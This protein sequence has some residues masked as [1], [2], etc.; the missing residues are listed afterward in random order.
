MCPAW[1]KPFP[2]EPVTS[3]P[4]LANYLDGQMDRWLQAE[5]RSSSN[6]PSSAAEEWRVL[7]NVQHTLA[8]FHGRGL[9]RSLPT[10]PAFRR[11]R[12]NAG[13]CAEKLRQ[14][15]QE[16]L[17]GHG[18][19]PSAGDGQSETRDSKC[20]VVLRSKAAG[21]LVLGLEVSPVTSARYDVLK[22]LVDAG[23]DGLSLAELIRRS[24]HG[25]ARNVLKNLAGT[26]SAWQQV[27]LLPGAPGRRYRLLFQ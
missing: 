17:Q 26:S 16:L 11:T 24:G 9:I 15:L 25:S 12:L 13:R 22:A 6:P 5:T 21:P 7:D 10:V 4:A 18:P 19:V 23:E 27:I 14:G 20:C 8:W 1:A 3:L 2:A